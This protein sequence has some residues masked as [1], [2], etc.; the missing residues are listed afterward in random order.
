MFQNKNCEIFANL[1]HNARAS[2]KYMFRHWDWY[3]DPNNCP[4]EYKYYLKTCNNSAS[5]ARGFKKNKDKW[6]GKFF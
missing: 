2:K 3:I 1:H 6:K 5:Y 4:E